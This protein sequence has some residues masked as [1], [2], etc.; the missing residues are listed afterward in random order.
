MMRMDPF[1]SYQLYTA[2]KLHFESQSYDAFKYNFKTSA[3]PKSFYRRKDK[4]FFAKLGNKYGK[5]L[6]DYYVSNFVKGVSYVGDMLNESG[7]SNWSDY[8]RKHQSLHRIFEV[9]LGTL[10]G[11]I[12]KGMKFDELF[13]CDSMNVPFILKLWLREEICIET[14]II[15]DSILG[16]IERS[17][18]ILN[19]TII[20]PDAYR[21]IT[22]YKP[23]VNFDREKCITLCKK[24]FT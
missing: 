21:T 24:R 5:D 15:L 19:E 13:E 8:Q 17:N 20:W 16:F 6:R 12:V 9:D 23:F 11:Y 10:D 3:N 4:Y 2:L 18:K 7:E 1:E 22:K 14:L